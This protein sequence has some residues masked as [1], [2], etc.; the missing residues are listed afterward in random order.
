M[1]TI[2]HLSGTVL[3]EMS[4]AVEGVE[5]HGVQ[6]TVHKNCSSSG[7]WYYIW[8]NQFT[9]VGDETLLLVLLRHYQ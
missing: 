8:R 7:N 6:F 9:E 2:F 1:K 5:C 4:T 3:T